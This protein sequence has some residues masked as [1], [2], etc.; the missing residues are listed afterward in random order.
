MV[1]ELERRTGLSFEDLMY[2]IWREHIK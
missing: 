2:D 1:A